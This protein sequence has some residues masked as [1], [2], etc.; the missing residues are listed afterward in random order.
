MLTRV[1]AVFLSA[2]GVAGFTKRIYVNKLLPLRV[3]LPLVKQALA[4]RRR[5]TELW[6]RRLGIRWLFSL[7]YSVDCLPK[8]VEQI[9]LQSLVLG[10]PVSKYLGPSSVERLLFWQSVYQ[11]PLG[12][13]VSQ[14]VPLFAAL[15]W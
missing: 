3:I 6:Y 11:M 10:C 2:S 12:Y 15:R 7:W 13:C 1:S 4:H 8:T 9:E 14:P 5:F